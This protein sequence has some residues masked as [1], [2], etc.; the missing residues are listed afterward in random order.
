MAAIEF[1]T[2]DPK[3]ND[4][5]ETVENV[6]KVMEELMDKGY[7]MVGQRRESVEKVEVKLEKVEVKPAPSNKQH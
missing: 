4:S 2:W 5:H 1:V 3:A 6:I 7:Q